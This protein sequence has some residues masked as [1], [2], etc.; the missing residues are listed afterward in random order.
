MHMQQLL[1]RWSSL[2]HRLMLWKRPYASLLLRKTQTCARKWENCS[3]AFLTRYTALKTTATLYLFVRGKHLS[4]SQNMSQPKDTVGPEMVI[5]NQKVPEQSTALSLSQGQPRKT[6]EAMK[7][8]GI[9]DFET[10]LCYC[11]LFLFW[12]LFVHSEAVI[13][14]PMLTLRFGIVSDAYR[15]YITY[16]KDEIKYKWIATNV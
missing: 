6:A 9:I 4:S 7:T 15:T 3:R 11:L 13:S 2:D 8:L 5:A 12:I 1:L 16:N 10:L 14:L